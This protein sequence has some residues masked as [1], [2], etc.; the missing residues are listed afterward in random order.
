[1][2]THSAVQKTLKQIRKEIQSKVPTLVCEGE[3][4]VRKNEEVSENKRG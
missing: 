2:K 1:M 4:W 3:T